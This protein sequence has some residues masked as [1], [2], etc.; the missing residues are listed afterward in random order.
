MQ[1]LSITWAHWMHSHTNVCPS[2]PPVLAPGA[3]SW[4]EGRLRA[5]LP[6]PEASMLCSCIPVHAPAAALA[7][8]WQVNPFLSAGVPGR[9]TPFSLQRLL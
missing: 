3:E 5:R 7:G 1:A 4:W 9:L 2:Q 6:V 8:A